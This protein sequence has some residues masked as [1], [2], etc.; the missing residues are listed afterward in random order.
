MKEEVK[1]TP[2]LEFRLKIR[3]ILRELPKKIFE[4]SRGRYFDGETNLMVAVGSAV[5]KRG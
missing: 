5:Y 4:L 2:H 3:D 1:Y